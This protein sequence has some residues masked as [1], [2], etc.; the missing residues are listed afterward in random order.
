[1]PWM[2]SARLQNVSAPSALAS[3]VLYPPNHETDG[4]TSASP[5]PEARNP[6][7][8]GHLERS[9]TVATCGLNSSRFSN[10]QLS[11]V[12]VLPTFRLRFYSSLA[13]SSLSTFFL[14]NFKFYGRSQP[15]RRGPD[16]GV[17]YDFGMCLLDWQSLYKIAKHRGSGS[18]VR[19]LLK[20]YTRPCVQA[21]RTSEHSAL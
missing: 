18:L 16:F 11:F 7:R 17:E 21:L 13:Q 4:S 14:W 19:Q 9:S 2:F 10:K 15:R 12:L 1:M 3:Y 20:S 6:C 5:S 8:S